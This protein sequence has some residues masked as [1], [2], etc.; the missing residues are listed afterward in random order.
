M[1]KNIFVCVYSHPEDNY[2]KNLKF[3]WLQ[4]AQ[5]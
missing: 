2:D 3:L 1:F 4:L 5:T